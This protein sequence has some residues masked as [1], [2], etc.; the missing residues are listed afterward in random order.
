MSETDDTTP[1]PDP[2]LPLAPLDDARLARALTLQQIGKGVVDDLPTA[3]EYEPIEG[4][5]QMVRLAEKLAEQAVIIRREQG[6]SWTDIGK[7]A[8]ISR[9]AAHDRWGTAV[10]TWVAL[11]RHRQAAPDLLVDQLDSW[12]ADIDPERPD[13]ISSGLPSLHDPAARRAAQDQRDEAQRLHAE[14]NTYPEQESDAFNRAF[15][16]TGT[17]EH[18]ARR[19]EWA[20]V[21]LEHAAL[22][23]RL[24]QVEPLAATEHRRRARTQRSLADEIAAKA[25]DRTTTTEN[26]P[27]A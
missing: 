1:E 16:A 21:H 12:Y 24:A 27:A 4:A 11:G 22:L 3:D 7:E 20:A 15:Q 14:L 6:A 13:A 26:E 18:P 19:R 10:E 9:Q 5:L 2:R 23:D 17:P 25:T 8:G